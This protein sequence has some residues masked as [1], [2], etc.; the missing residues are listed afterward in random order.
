MLKLT[1]V[2]EQ[3][4]LFAETLRDIANV[5]AGALVFGQVLSD[6]P[7]SFWLAAAGMV[8]WCCLVTLAVHLV[9]ES[10]S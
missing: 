1:L 7:F 8:L 4:V 3:R 9:K 6:A 2:P 5:A 10:T